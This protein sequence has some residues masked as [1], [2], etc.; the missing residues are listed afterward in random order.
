LSVRLIDA[1]AEEDRG[2][3][4]I[5]LSWQVTAILLERLREVGYQGTVLIPL[6]EPTL[7][8]LG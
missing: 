6:P 2:E 4:V 3:L 7:V 1:L 8:T 5:L